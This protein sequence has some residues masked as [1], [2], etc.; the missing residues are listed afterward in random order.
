MAMFFFN[1]LQDGETYRTISTETI[2]LNLTKRQMTNCTSWKNNTVENAYPFQ[3]CKQLGLD[4]QWFFLI[5]PNVKMQLDF[6]QIF[7]SKALR[8]TARQSEIQSCFQ[9]TNISY[10]LQGFVLFFSLSFL[11]YGLEINRCILEAVSM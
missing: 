11:S 3:F 5:L 7:V 9:T 8:M 1:R 4:Q 6:D 2:Q 10:T